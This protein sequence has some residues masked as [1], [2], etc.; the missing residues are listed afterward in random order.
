VPVN[1]KDPAYQRKP[2]RCPATCSPKAVVEWVQ[3]GQV[4]AAAAAG[5]GAR[6]D[7]GVRQAHIRPEAVCTTGA[8][9]HLSRQLRRRRAF[10]M[11]VVSSTDTRRNC[12]GLSVCRVA[13]VIVSWTAKW[14]GACYAVNVHKLPARTQVHGA[15]PVLGQGAAAHRV[16]QQVWAW[17]S[18]S[19]QLVMRCC[20]R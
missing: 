17:S 15:D 6:P 5:G 18:T 20:T 12:D 13:A 19:L 16:A 7:G 11:A 14:Q 2:A 10:A 3:H 4:R 1:R 9:K 8:T